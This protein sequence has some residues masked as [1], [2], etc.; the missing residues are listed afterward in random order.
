[1]ATWYRLYVKG[2]GGLVLDQWYQASAICDATT[3][4]VPS[5]ALGSGDHVWWVQPYN[6]AGYGPWKS[7]TFKVSP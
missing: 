4:S 3:C 7:A 6:S 2:P 1:M 5:P